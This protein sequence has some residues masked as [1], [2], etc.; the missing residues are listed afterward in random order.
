MFGV[1]ET[2]IQGL[3][4]GF[5]IWG[6]RFEGFRASDLWLGV[7]VCRVRIQKPFMVWSSAKT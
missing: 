5:T 3:G 4:L 6:L 7:R 1:L 2:L